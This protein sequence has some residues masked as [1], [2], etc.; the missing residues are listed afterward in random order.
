M[1]IF[2]PG[3]VVAEADT[4]LLLGHIEGIEQL[5]GFRRYSI[6]SPVVPAALVDQG[7]NVFFLVLLLPSEQLAFADGILWRVAGI[8]PGHKHGRG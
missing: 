1:R 2:K 3:N 4:A 8:E 5:P 6:F 7:G